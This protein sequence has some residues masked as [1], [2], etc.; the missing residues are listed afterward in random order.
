MTGEFGQFFQVSFSRTPGV[1]IPAVG[2]QS[3]DH[4]SNGDEFDPGSHA[5][6]V[7]AFVLS[8]FFTPV[9]EEFQK[10]G[11]VKIFQ[12]ATAVW[13]IVTMQA[14]LDRAE[15]N[16]GK[17]VDQFF[18]G[19]LISGRTLSQQLFVGTCRQ[20]RHRIPPESFSSF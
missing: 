20:K 1:R 2:S 16:V 9:F 5:A 19:R 7:D 17:A 11:V 10:N 15:N 4:D 6:A 18:P 13:D 8:K 14:E 3:V 12:I